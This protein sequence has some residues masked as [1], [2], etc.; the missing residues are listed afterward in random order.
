MQETTS[1]WKPAYQ[2]YPTLPPA[3]WPRLLPSRM[4]SWCESAWTDFISTAGNCR[5]HR[6]HICC[7]KKISS[8]LWVVP[9]AKLPAGSHCSHN[10]LP[11]HNHLDQEIAA[12]CPVVCP[13]AAFKETRDMGRAVRMVIQVADDTR[14]R[15]GL[16]VFCS[17]VAQ[18]KVPY[19]PLLALWYQQGGKFRFPDPQDSHQTELSNKPWPC[20]NISYDLFNV[21]IMYHLQVKTPNRVIKT[22]LYN[23]P[24]PCHNR[25]E[26]LFYALV[27]RSSGW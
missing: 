15:L 19:A 1:F 7:A 8:F 14:L 6:Y 21:F 23:K 3:G 5:S 27:Q 26:N 4:P 17:N 20:N 13:A 11:H 18:C 9:E 24:R 12:S 22:E 16:S 25:A 10:I 2:R